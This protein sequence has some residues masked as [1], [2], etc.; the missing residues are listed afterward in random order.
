MEL[1][2]NHQIRSFDPAPSSLE[3]LLVLE[4]SGKTQGVAAAINN[5]V[6]PKDDWAKTTLKPHDQ[7][8]LITAS[9]GG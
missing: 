3:E 1:T 8:I 4:L 6:I 5:H 2:I 7:I 9:Q